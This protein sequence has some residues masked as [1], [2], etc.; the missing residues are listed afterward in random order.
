MTVT[1]RP[2]HGSDP[3]VELRVL[4]PMECLVEGSPLHLGGTKQRG[5]LALLASE[6]GRAVAT[7]V[8]VDRLWGGRAPERANATL[9]VHVSNLRKALAPAA[10]ALGGGELVVTRR[11]GYL[12]ELPDE[13]LDATRMERL[14]AEGRRLALE[15]RSAQAA[16]RLDVAVRL[17]RGE[18]LSDLRA[19]S[20]W[21]DVTAPLVRLHESAV[22]E[23]LALGLDAGRHRELL[24]ELEQL[25]ARRR[26][27]EGVRGMV[28]LALYRSGRQADALAVYQE[29]RAALLDELGVDPGPAIRELE[30][31]ILAQDPT[32][33]VAGRPASDV[34]FTTVLRSSLVLVPAVLVVESER[35]SLDR[36]V[37]TIGRRSGQDVVVDDPRASR[38][39]AVVRSSGGRHVVE[40]LGS[41]NGTLVN[42]APLVGERLLEDGDVIGIG[43]VEVR[44]E[45]GG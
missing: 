34:E 44:F 23:R 20:W 21:A 4:G 16:D 1:E 25:L 24:T 35:V 18:P 14:V 22:L 40:D 45:L 3:S 2:S 6:P 37:T 32:L 38:A 29:G 13:L 30:G 39:H 31:R 28:M 8:L 17:W 43:S 12:L 5:V 33:A 41:T 7:D 10:A 42:G 19:E 36:A 27:D 9:Q 15:G 11:P 26:L